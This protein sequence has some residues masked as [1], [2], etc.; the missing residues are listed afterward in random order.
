MSTT[1]QISR[2]VRMRAQTPYPPIPTREARPARESA[3]VRPDEKRCDPKERAMSWTIPFTI[4]VEADDF[5]QAMY[6]AS[7]ALA[8]I[9]FFNEE[10][11]VKLVDY[12]KAG[13]TGE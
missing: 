12:E 7:V 13:N 4:T 11:H 5:H 3:T 6:R 1:E 10:L 9:H 8:A 2:P